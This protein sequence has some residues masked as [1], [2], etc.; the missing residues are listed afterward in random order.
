MIGICM[1]PRNSPDQH[2]ETREAIIQALEYLLFKHE[3]TDIAVKQIC[4]EAHVSKPTFYR[5]FHNKDSIVHWMLAESI[6]RGIAEVGRRYSWYEGFYNTALYFYR[7]RTLFSDPQNAGLTASFVNYS[8]GYFKQILTETLTKHKNI[9]ITPK[10][11]FQIDAFNYAQGYISRQWA[12]DGMRL[13][14]DT[15]ADYM[16]SV[17]P[18]DLFLLLNDPEHS[19]TKGF[20]Q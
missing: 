13:H 9:E 18:L 4:T 7:H 1:A 10:L 6:K 16:A 12:K 2:S 19:K 11:S 8:S 14:P 20:E 17:V 15:Y 5:Y 3:Y